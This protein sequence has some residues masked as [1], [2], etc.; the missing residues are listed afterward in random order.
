MVW[1]GT[2]K[3]G[4]GVKDKYVVAWY[5]EKKAEPTSP[6]LSKS[7]IGKVCSNNGYNECYNEMAL[8]AH[9]KRRKHHETT[10]L[11]FDANLARSIQLEM[12][13]GSFRGIMPKATDRAPS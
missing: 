9:N 6:G 4:F 12:N 11:I 10:G 7:N 3:V 5:C 13:K 2:T 1:K 8:A